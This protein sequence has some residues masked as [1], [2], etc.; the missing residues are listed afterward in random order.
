MK[1]N[2]TQLL[3]AVWVVSAFLLISTPCFFDWDLRFNSAFRS[4]SSFSELRGNP[5]INPPIIG[6]YARHLASPVLDGFYWVKENL[7]VGYSDQVWYLTLLQNLVL[8]VC[9]FL[10]A[11]RISKSVSV[12]AVVLGVFVLGK[13]SLASLGYFLSPQGVAYEGT[14]GFALSLLGM[15]LWFYEKRLW[16]T[17]LLALTAYVHIV[18]S[19]TAFGFIALADLI[20]IFQKREKHSPAVLRTFLYLVLISPILYLIWAEGRY[21]KG[22]DLNW[23]FF[24]RL[25]DVR[26]P[27]H[28]TSW[29][30]EGSSLPFFIASA[31]GVLSLSS[32]QSRG[33]ERTTIDKYW[34]LL[35]G[36]A[37]TCLIAIVGTE[38]FRSPTIASA[39]LTRTSLFVLTLLPTVL[40]TSLVGRN[41]I[42]RWSLISLLGL[43]LLSVSGANVIGQLGF[44]I[45]VGLVLAFQN[46]LEKE[47][48]LTWIW[49]GLWTTYFSVLVYVSHFSPKALAGLG[50]CLF[51]ISAVLAFRFIPRLPSLRTAN[52][53]IPLVLVFFSMFAWNVSPILLDSARPDSKKVT[54][55]HSIGEVRQWLAAHSNPQELILTDPDLGCAPNCLDRHVLFNTML[56]G[57]SY[58]TK[59][60]LP[61]EEKILQSLFGIDLM[62]DSDYAALKADLSGELKRRY[63]GIDSTKLKELLAQ[64]PHLSLKIDLREEKTAQAEFPIVFENEMYRIS[65]LRNF[66]DDRSKTRFGE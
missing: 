54:R 8:S 21:L 65:R 46:G 58:Y 29:F 26:K 22:L 7:G 32:L 30:P 66:S 10:I 1:F 33:V 4:Q 6:G 9:L 14:F 25:M 19:L 15:T 31:T 16:A 13:F 53:T 2:R 23:T 28:V 24:W 45:A 42:G 63:N 38:L 20:G 43:F 44:F 61:E 50:V 40:L 12:S 27:W 17:V 3:S 36:S 51:S 35:L 37:V 47:N 60:V 59:G 48:L 57:M 18:H 49:A 64:Y 41:E 5:S 55:W 39:T 56:M 34:A 52:L 62:K 11:F